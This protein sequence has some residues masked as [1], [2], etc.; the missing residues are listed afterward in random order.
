MY[1]LKEAGVVVFDQLVCKLSPYRYEPMPLT[2][3][4]W[5]H[6]TKRTTLTTCIDDFGVQYFSKKDA[7]HLI[8]AIK[9]NCECTIDWDRKTY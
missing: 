2:A 1:G 8:N 5:R 9:S 4:L 6:K 3:R 7:E